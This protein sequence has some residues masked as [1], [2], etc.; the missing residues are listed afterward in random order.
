MP[1][2][3]C[4]AARSATAT[5]RDP[6]QAPNMVAS[7]RNSRNMLEALT[8]GTDEPGWHWQSESKPRRG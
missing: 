2:E 6:A 8:W 7:Q 5:S 3:G 1:T 4:P